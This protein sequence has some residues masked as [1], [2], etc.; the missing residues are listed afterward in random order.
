MAQDVVPLLPHVHIGRGLAK[1]VVEQGQTAEA[2]TRNVSVNCDQ[3]D[4]LVFLA[5]V[6]V[7]CVR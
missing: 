5:V 2:A 4:G 6:P 7:V 1:R 3:F